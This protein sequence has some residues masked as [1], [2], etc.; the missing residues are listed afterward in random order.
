MSGLRTGRIT[1]YSLKESKVE[2]APEEKKSSL[3]FTDLEYLEK[4]C[5]I[6]RKQYDHEADFNNWKIRIYS[7]AF[8]LETITFETIKTNKRLSQC[9]SLSAVFIN[10][11]QIP[12]A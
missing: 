6:S 2:A 9:E 11:I 8:L 3:A 5:G 1:S 4:S 10:N 7:I 12:D